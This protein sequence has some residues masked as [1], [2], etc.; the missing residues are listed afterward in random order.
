VLSNPEDPNRSDV[1]MM[2]RFPGKQ[3]RS[4]TA[5]SGGEKSVAAISLIL[6]LQGMTPAQF[7]IFDE[8]DAHLDI[9]HTTKLVNLLKTMSRERQIIVVTL[10]DAVAEKAD[11]L[12]GIYMVN[13]VSSIVKTSLE[14]VAVSG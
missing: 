11:A 13:G 6:A 7:Y 1:E 2:V 8:V 10:K 9:N 4:T 12:F 3:I 5:V 14:E